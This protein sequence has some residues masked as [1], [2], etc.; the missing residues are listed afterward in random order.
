M[1]K[2]II[3]LLLVAAV[4][5]STATCAYAASGQKFNDVPQSAWYYDCVSYV[6]EKGIMDGLTNNTFGPDIN[7]TKAQV[8]VALYNLYGGGS[9]SGSV[10]SAVP[11]DDWFSGAAEWAVSNGIVSTSDS[12]VFSPEE[13]VTRQ[14]LAVMLMNY[15]NYAGGTTSA[16]SNLVQYGDA[17]N[18]SSSAYSAVSWAV[19]SGLIGGDGAD[20]IYP[21]EASTRAEFALL[22][23]KFDENVLSSKEGFVQNSTAVPILM[24]HSFSDDGSVTAWTMPHE[25]F[26]AIIKTLK[27]AGYNA[28][29]YRDLVK[30]VED[31]T[32]LPSNPIIISLDDG[33]LNNLTYAYPALK[34]YGFCAEV[35][36]IGCYVGRDSIDGVPILP[37]FSFGDL[38][39]EK[40]WQKVFNIESHTYMMHMETTGSDLSKGR[41]T[42][43]RAPGESEQEYIKALIKDFKRSKTQIVSHVGYVTAM[44]YP[45]GTFTKESEQIAKEL[46][47]KVTATT[48]AGTNIITVG[49]PDGLYL[50]NRINVSGDMTPEQVLELLNRYKA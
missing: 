44:T 30:Y 48:D 11:E 3:C 14:D 39:K 29:Y 20:N 37:Y 31:G 49:Q 50:L 18:I 41:S 8:V 4:S 23:M 15:V 32:P 43:E 46:G 40:G 35:S 42:V 33:Y 22:L 12:S 45:H 36:L 26:E 21:N 38:W 16:R 19:A 17:K 6:S 1:R 27:E 28:V 7:V 5:F 34:Q 2:S 13:T 10:I 25:R 9:E 47:F 24:F